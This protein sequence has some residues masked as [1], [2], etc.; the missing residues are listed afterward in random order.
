MYVYRIS[1]CSTKWHKTA[2]Q[3]KSNVKQN[4]KDHFICVTP[5]TWEFREM[6]FSNHNKPLII[7]KSALASTPIVL[8]LMTIKL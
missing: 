5:K 8:M 1:L 3:M 7:D 6:I 2:L 4:N